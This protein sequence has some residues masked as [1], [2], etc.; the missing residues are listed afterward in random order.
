M[1]DKTITHEEF[2]K[3][4]KT[5]IDRS[6]CGLSYTVKSALSHDERMENNQ[7]FQMDTWIIPRE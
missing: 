6:F 3:S 1:W 7:T 5:G 2:P 4:M